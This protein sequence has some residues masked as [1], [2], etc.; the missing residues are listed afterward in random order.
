MDRNKIFSCKFSHFLFSIASGRISRTQTR[1]N[2]SEGPARGLDFPER[3]HGGPQFRCGQPGNHRRPLPG[4]HCGDHQVLQDY[5][6]QVSSM[7]NL[8]MIAVEFI[9]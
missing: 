9:N 1:P 8:N 6:R 7:E 3:V 5:H 4:G 2:C